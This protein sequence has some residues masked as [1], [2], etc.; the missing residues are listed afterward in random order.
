M[1]SPEFNLSVTEAAPPIQDVLN[2][3]DDIQ[4]LEDPIQQEEVW[5][6]LRTTRDVRGISF[7]EEGQDIR[8]MMGEVHTP[9]Q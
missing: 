7:E 4:G 5:H 1:T 9:V 6:Q 3:I 8:K 2:T